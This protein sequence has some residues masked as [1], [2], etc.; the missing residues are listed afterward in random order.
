MSQCLSYSTSYSKRSSSRP[1]VQVLLLLEIEHTFFHGAP[2]LSKQVVFVTWTSGLKTYNV[3]KRPVKSCHDPNWGR[4]PDSGLNCQCKTKNTINR[5]QFLN[6]QCKIR[7]E[8]L[9]LSKFCSSVHIMKLLTVRFSPLPTP[10]S[11][12]DSRQHILTVYS[13][14]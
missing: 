7:K 4:I 10:L 9:I 5:K 2:P 14:P 8:T 11:P 12:S 3:L 1:V 6:F 13:L